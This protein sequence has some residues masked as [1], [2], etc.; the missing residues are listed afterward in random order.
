MHISLWPGKKLQ[1]RVA[2]QVQKVQYFPL[3]LYRFPQMQ[4]NQQQICAGG[5]PTNKLWAH[6]LSMAERTEAMFSMSCSR[7]RK[8]I[9][10][11]TRMSFTKMLTESVQTPVALLPSHF[12]LCLNITLANSRLFEWCMYGSMLQVELL[13]NRQNR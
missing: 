7:L 6:G 13:L 8:R 3:P 5:K 1:L 4:H 12:S 9:P 2:F 10:R 11:K